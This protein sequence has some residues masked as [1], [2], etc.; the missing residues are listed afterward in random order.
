M[1]A[2][3]DEKNVIQFTGLVVEG[4]SMYGLPFVHVYVPNTPRGA[5]TSN[6]GYFSMAVYAGD[7]VI[8]DMIGYKDEHFIIPSDA[9]ENMSVIVHL[10]PDTTV[11]A[12]VEIYPYPNL[13]EFKRAFLALDLP[14]RDIDNMNENLNERLMKRM[15]YHS[16]AD[17]SMNHR[18]FMEKQVVQTEQQFFYPTVPL[19]DP[20]AWARFFKDLKKYKKKKAA[21]D[22]D[23]LDDE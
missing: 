14:Q 10:E 12:V 18:Y 8:F 3:D 13:E 17:G 23:Y 19:L 1:F 9:E 5:I 16:G 6:Y 2:Q 22:Y 4:D 11:M 21:G 15:L 7:S 20:F